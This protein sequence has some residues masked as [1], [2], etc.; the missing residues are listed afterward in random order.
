MP[1]FYLKGDVYE[2]KTIKLVTLPT[3]KL[4][5][6]RELGVENVQGYVKGETSSSPHTHVQESKDFIK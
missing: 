1:L 5:A 3:T 4:D 6:V 2:H